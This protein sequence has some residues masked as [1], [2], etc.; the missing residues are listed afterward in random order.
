M[1]VLD[2]W[3]Y[4]LPVIITHV[5]GILD[6][7]FD[8]KTMLFFTTGDIDALAEQMEKMINND[9]LR[10]SIA[11]ESTLLVHTTFYVKQ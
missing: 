4:G 9:N 6:I 8:G 3:A 10:Q 7:A 2:A 1:G 5:G 11:A